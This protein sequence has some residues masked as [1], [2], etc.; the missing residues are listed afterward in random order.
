[1]A[2]PEQIAANRENAKK[3][4]RP[5][6]TATLKTQQQREILL[7]I[8]ENEIHEI[9]DALIEKAK[10]GDVQAAK[11][12]FDRAYGKA[13]QAHVT[14]DEDGNEMPI[15]APLMTTLDDEWST[16]SHQL[17]RK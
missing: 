8:L 15:L 16:Q 3:G 2:T 4:G 9:Y 12:I 1:M 5:K 14:K 7:E 17:P 13:P 10:K 6:S 11:E